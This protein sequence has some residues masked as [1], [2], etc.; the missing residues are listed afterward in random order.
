MLHCGIVGLPL[1]GKTT[2]FNVITRAGAEVKPYAG[3]RTDPNRAVVGVP[4]GRFDRLVDVHV[5]KKETPA[6]VEFVDLAG[7]SRG[8]GKGEGLGNAFL[9]FVADA[10]ALIHVI[11]CFD[12]AGVPH[13]EGSVDPLRD[14]EILELELIFRDLSVVENRLGKL[15]SK[16]KL[17]PEESAEKGLLER[18]LDRLTGEKPIRGL[19]MTQEEA[20]FLRGFAFVTSKPQIIALNMDE[21][22]P[23][24][25]SLPNW[26]TL[27][28]S[29]EER[30]LSMVGIYG[31]LEMDLLDLSP[32]EAAEFTEG[33]SIDEPA[34]DRLISEAYRTL[35]L[36]SFFTCGPDEVRAWTLRDGENAVDAAGAIHSDLARGFIR[37]VVVSYDDYTENGDS[38]ANCRDAGVLRQEGKDY[39]VRDG[40]IIEIRFN[41]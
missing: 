20:R 28:R 12:N 6:Q 22:Q 7:L 29:I 4:D 34:R 40:D 21:S 14:L 39:R 9:S 26:D 32:E 17:L 23:G 1:S 15:R 18:C 5:P 8:A 24:L 16:K 41:V 38:M 2:I 33:L 11:R 13:P 19:D 27:R 10:D 36:I 25:S 37:A 31:R 30:G 3:G 35:G